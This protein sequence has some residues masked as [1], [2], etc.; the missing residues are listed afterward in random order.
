MVGAE[1]FACKNGVITLVKVRRFA[2]KF[3]LDQCDILRD[4]TYVH[5]ACFVG[6]FV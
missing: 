6:Y 4:G 2:V 5:D 3:Q 1:P